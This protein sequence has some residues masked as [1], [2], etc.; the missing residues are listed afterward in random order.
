MTMD[1]TLSSLLHGYLPNKYMDMNEIILMMILL[2]DLLKAC[3]KQNSLL[4]HNTA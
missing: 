2:V 4:E 3:A 1:S